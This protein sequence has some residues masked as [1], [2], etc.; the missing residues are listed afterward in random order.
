MG[1]RSCGK[2]N[3]IVSI[4][5]L[6]DQAWCN[7]FVEKNVKAKTYPLHLV[8]CT[9]CNMLQ[10]DYTVPKEVMFK[11][12]DYLSGTTKTLR[13]HFYNLA[14]ENVEQ[15]GLSSSDC[16]L[17]IGG[18]DG[19]QLFQYTI[20]GLNNVINVESAD[21]QAE[22]S[23]S[24]GIQ[25]IHAFFNE[26]L[27]YKQFLPGSVMLINA[28]GVFF[29]LEELHSVIRAI[30]YILSQSGI[31]I[32][33]FMYAGM[34]IEKNTYDM[35]YHEHLLYYTLKSLE[36]LLEPYGLT[37]FDA[38]ESNIH[39]GSII[40]KICHTKHKQ[41]AEKTKRYLELKE[42]DSK[43]TL[44]NFLDFGEKITK[45]RYKLRKFLLDLK[46]DKKVKIYGYG[47]PAKGN[48]LLTYENIKGLLDKLVEINPLKVGKYTPVTRIPISMEDPNDVP[49][50][51]LLLSHNFEHEILEKNKD[52]IAKGIKF[53][54][55]FP[56]IKIIQKEDVNE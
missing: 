34:M 31:F 29:H 54:T 1:C 24:A 33:Q 20:L 13:E 45:N 47:A 11:K 48:T 21:V 30:K 10:L 2:T 53:I 27:V 8:Y 16:V 56:E 22:I 41:S 28:S 46:K 39:S 42:K 40:A 19:T 23:K 52:L 5:N 6:G 49:D 35:I 4:L 9:N 50:Y 17:D 18:N 7:D 37:V 32:V 26:D 44:S 55:P 38:Y 43:Y 15:F 36:N 3:T 14:K 51:Y 25:T 12:H